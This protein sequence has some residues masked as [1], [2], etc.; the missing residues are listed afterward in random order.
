MDKVEK[1]EGNLVVNAE[2]I[3]VKKRG[4]KLLMMNQ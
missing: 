3:G 4:E 2:Q 1:S